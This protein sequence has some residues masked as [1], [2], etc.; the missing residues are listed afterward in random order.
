MEQFLLIISN[1]ILQLIEW[2]LSLLVFAII[3]YA[4]LSWLIAF[5]VLNTRHPL[6]GQ[7]ER[8]LF[9]VTRPIVRPLQRIVPPIG[10]VDITP[11][12]AWGIITFL[13]IP[14]VNWAR[15]DLMPM[16]IMS[17]FGG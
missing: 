7:L 14:V 13:A 6:V 9:A 4:I 1:G 11:L 3:A 5:N 17:A 10:M 12:I 2:L 15:V 8:F 16:L